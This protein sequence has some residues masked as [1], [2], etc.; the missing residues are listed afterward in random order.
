MIHFAPGRACLLGEHCDWAGGSD[1]ACVVVPLSAGVEVTV[2]R[3]DWGVAV[4]S[5]YGV[6]RLGP[7]GR[8]VAAD[9]NRYVAAVV[10]ELRRRGVK[11]PGARVVVRATLPAGRG[12]SSSA[13]VCVATA[14]ALAAHAG[15]EVDIADVAYRAEHDDLGVNC[16]EMDP[17]ACAAARPLFIDWGPPRTEHPLRV[18]VMTPLLVAA[19]PQEVP[20]AP[21]LAALAE[22]RPEEAFASWGRGAT[23]AAE[24]LEAGDLAA[25]GQEM[26]QAQAVYEGLDIAALRA[27]ALESWCGRLRELGALG[28]KFSGAGGDRSLVALFGDPKQ[29]EAATTRLEEAG[30]LVLDASLEGS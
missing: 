19:F 5:A 12:F 30:L 17:L 18:G 6:T 4:H 13:A 23:R 24:A 14:R 9:P 22:A 27:P 8:C 7:E 20:A 16:G 2:R 25:L 11:V 28:A 26:N 10:R 21:I 15:V 29:L 3:A 1:A